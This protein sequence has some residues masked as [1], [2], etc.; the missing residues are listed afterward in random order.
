MLKLE[1]THHDAE[2][3]CVILWKQFGK[4]SQ[5]KVIYILYTVIPIKE[6]QNLSD[7]E[8]VTMGLWIRRA[9]FC[10]Q[11]QKRS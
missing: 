2:Y 10:I 3:V 9:S 8:I 5:G 6:K 4:S 7:G 1:E 11:L